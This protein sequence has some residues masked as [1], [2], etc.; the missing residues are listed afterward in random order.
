MSQLSIQEL[1]RR[2]LWHREQEGIRRY[3]TPLY[4][5][6]GRSALLDAY[7]EALDLAVYLRQVIEEMTVGD[8]DLKTASPQPAPLPPHFQAARQRTDDETTSLEQP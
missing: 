5:Y 6:N 1:V 7:E 2:D 8:F 4:P 3:G